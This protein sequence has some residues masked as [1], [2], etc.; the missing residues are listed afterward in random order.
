MKCEYRIA[1]KLPCVYILERT[2]PIKDPTS[3]MFHLIT[4]IDLRSYIQLRAPLNFH[5]LSAFFTP[6]S[7][8]ANGMWVCK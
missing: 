1:L 8:L 4:L 5:C 6:G 2:S 3:L 7:V